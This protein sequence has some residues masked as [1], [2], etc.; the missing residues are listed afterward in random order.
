MLPSP[1]AKFA[2]NP[3]LSGRNG[4]RTL[5]L[6]QFARDGVVLLGRL[7]A[8]RDNHLWL[9][10]DLKD[11]LAKADQ[12]EAELV[13]LVDGFIAQSGV[14]APLENLPV[15]HDG[16]AAQEITELDLWSAG[17]S[18]IIW[19][20]GFAFDFGLVKLPVFDSDG[21]PIQQ[22]GVTAYPGL[23]FVGLPWLYKYKS[24]QLVGVGEDAEYITSM[25]APAR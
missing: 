8:G 14:D 20:V 4:G 16:F 7:Q 19:A 10:A 9:A 11:N 23:F 15:L 5:N 24:G 21:Y 2:A 13:K 12:F 17:A 1:K 3:H 18:T 6:H 22:R 25:I